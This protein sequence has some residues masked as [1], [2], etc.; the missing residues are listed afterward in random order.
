MNVLNI[1]IV[2]AG[3]CITLVGLL[4]VIVCIG[5]LFFDSEEIDYDD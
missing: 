2:V 4:A 3:S 5:A 1:L